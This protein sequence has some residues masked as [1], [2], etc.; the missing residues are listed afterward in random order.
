M[1]PAIASRH[2]PWAERRRRA[3]E[4]RARHP[5]AEEVLRLFLSLV[6]VYEDACDETPPASEVVSYARERVLP[7]VVDATVAAG[8]ERLAQSAAARLRA[9]GRPLSGPGLAGP[10]PGGAGAGG[11]RGLHRAAGRSPLPQ[12]RGASPAELLRGLGRVPG[13]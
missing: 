6:P 4:L 5:F 1:E 3:E 13:N 2:D 7:R 9:P 8:P 10:A 12:L 11:C